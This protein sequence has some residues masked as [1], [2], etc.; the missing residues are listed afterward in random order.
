MLLPL[1]VIMSIDEAEMILPRPDHLRS[2][3]IVVPT[4]TAAFGG[5]ILTGVMAILAL[6]DH[7]LLT[8]VQE[9]MSPLNDEL[10]LAGL[11]LVSGLIT[12]IC[13]SRERHRAELRQ[14]RSVSEV[15]QRV[16]LRPLPS[17]VGPLRIASAYLAAA[18]EARIGGDL[19]AATRIAHG[20]RLIIGDVRGKG[21]TSISDAALLLCTFREAARRHI[22]LRRLVAHLDDS[23]YRNLMEF[24]ETDADAAECFVT[25]A[26]LEVPDDE[27]AIRLV[28]RG[29]PP[30]LLL[31]DGRVLTLN[32]AHTGPPLGL[33]ELGEPA[34][35][36]HRDDRFPFEPGDILLLYTDGALE[37]RDRGGRFYPFAERVRAWRGGSPDALIRYLRNDLLAHV[38]QNLGDDAALVAIQRT[39][40]APDATP[41]GREDG[42]DDRGRARRER[43]GRGQ[44]DLRG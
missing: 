9:D 44:S 8:S 27:P 22:T 13:F 35:A 6:G 23:V 14:V 32:P 12:G 31:R 37:A 11:M 7:Y 42:H 16:V 5:P 40:P 19:Y 39:S 36:E 1:F 3:L 4:L 24:A 33:G 21:L 2:L 17:R 10:E 18:A 38:H 26:V 20:T 30:P 41:S 29:H 15:A 25:A 34:S 43:D 28:D